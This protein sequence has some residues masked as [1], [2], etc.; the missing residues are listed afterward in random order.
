MFN[1]KPRRNFRQRKANSSEEEDEE[2]NNGDGEENEKAPVV[3]NKPFSLAQGRGISCS[4]KREATPPKPDS[5]DGEDG[6][7][8]GVP[9]ERK[10][11]GDGIKKK[12]NSVLSFSDDKGIIMV[13]CRQCFQR[14]TQSNPG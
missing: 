13:F 10:N 1:K 3:V 8:L 12:T 9:E 2:K 14:W 4:S 7:T 5:S 11:D 6:E